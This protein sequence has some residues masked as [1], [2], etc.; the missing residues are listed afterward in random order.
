MERVEESGRDERLG[1]YE[2]GRPNEDT[3]VYASKAESG[4]MCCERDA[5]VEA[6]PIVDVVEILVDDDYVEGI[7]R[8][9]R[10][11]CHHVNTDV[12]LPLA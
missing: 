5:I 7:R 11:I 9:N 2:R 12:F 1:P 8:V 6:N 3:L 10:N 4:Q